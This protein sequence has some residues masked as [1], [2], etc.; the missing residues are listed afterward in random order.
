MT[1]IL[2]FPG[3]AADQ[4]LFA[5]LRTPLPGLNVPAFITPTQGES[6][7]SYAQ[8]L[9]P[10]LAP[11]IPSGHSPWY[12]GGFSFGSQ[13]AQEI[14]AHL[15]ASGLRAPSGLILLC[16]VRGRH[17]IL[18]RFV[19]QQKLGALVPGWI[20]KRI[21]GPYA[22]HFARQCGLDPAQTH[23]LV[24]MARDND[25]AFLRWSAHACAHWKGTPR[26][27][28]LPILHIHGERDDIIP[29]PRREATMTLAGAGHLITLTHAAVVAEAIQRFIE[30][31]SRRS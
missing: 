5:S 17:Q 25:P 18:P 23:L 12:L 26:L 1:T 29:D 6:L 14:V 31:T 9:T 15:Q 19:R 21:Y 2:L 10:T 22:R 20:A 8:R 11:L 16:G 3:L 4:R 28:G 27:N 30:E 7:E 24:S 13:L